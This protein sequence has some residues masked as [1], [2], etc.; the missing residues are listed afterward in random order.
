[1]ADLRRF[2]NDAPIK[3]KR[4]GPRERM[5]RWVRRNRALAASAAVVLMV[6]ALVLAG[7][8]GF[9]VQDRANRLALA[10]HSAAAAVSASRAATEAGDLALA[11]RH[12]AQAVGQMGNDSEA[13]PDLAADIQRIQSEI[14]ARQSDII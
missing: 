12:V 14:D 6:S 4:P 1:A 11:N 3:A 5:I 8:I 9:F 2:L 10:A 7:S 13:L